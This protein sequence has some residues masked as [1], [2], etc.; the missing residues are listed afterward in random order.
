VAFPQTWLAAVAMFAAVL[1]LFRDAGRQGLVVAGSVRRLA[2]AV[3]VV[4]LPLAT[5]AV[6]RASV[7]GVSEALWLSPAAVPV[8]AA[9]GLS[10]GSRFWRVVG[11]WTFAG[12]LPYVLWAAFRVWRAGAEGYTLWPL[13]DRHYYLPH[14]PVLIGLILTASLLALVLVALARSTRHPAAA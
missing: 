11:I 13:I 12:A 3:L 1:V 10:L 6:L 8:V 5:Y 7:G 9:I 2:S 4:A 14:L